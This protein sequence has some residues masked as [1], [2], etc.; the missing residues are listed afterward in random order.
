[1]TGFAPRNPDFEALVRASFARQTMMEAVGAQM[2]SVE[3]GLVELRAPILATM[4]Q[5]HDFGHGGLSF[6][7]G[8]VAAGYSALS[9]QPA[10][11]DVL[12]VEMKINFLAPAQGV[13]LVARGRV[14]RPGRRMIVV[15]AEVSAV[16]EEGQEAPVALLQG[17]MIPASL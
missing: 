5:Q 9:L 16:D 15:G 12:T 6:T 10:G 4:R 17:T 7:L 1:M 2:V 8:D 14:I 3:P 13:E 11:Q